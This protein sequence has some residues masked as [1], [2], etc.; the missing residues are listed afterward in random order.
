M[1]HEKTRTRSSSFTLIEVLVTIAIISFLASLM[2]PSLRGGK[3]RAKS[4]VC[5]NNLRQISLAILLYANDHD[6][7]V[8]YVVEPM[9]GE[10]PSDTN[11]FPNSFYNVMCPRYLVAKNLICPSAVNGYPGTDPTGWKMT[12][13][14]LGANTLGSEWP[15]D[16][17]KADYDDNG[18]DSS[19]TYNFGVYTPLDGRPIQ[20]MRTVWLRP[21]LK[22]LATATEP[23][24]FPHPYRTT[25]TGTPMATDTVGMA[26]H[27][28]AGD[29]IH[30][31]Y[32]T[33][34]WSSLKEN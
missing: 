22:D 1:L 8:P 31:E 7:R 34:Y 19:G 24:V 10:D 3:Q 27:A 28:K 14:V 25:K 12:Y 13:Q 18:Y 30:I 5:M 20:C 4:I 11:A 26:L 21:L 2:A 33:K 29:D 9:S 32:E 15:W 23:N 16:A 17:S 6:Q